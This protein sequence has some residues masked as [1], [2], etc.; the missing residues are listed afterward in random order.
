VQPRGTSVAAERNGQS[1]TKLLDRQNRRDPLSVSIR[2]RQHQ[3]VADPAIVPH[4]YMR[5]RGDARLSSVVRWYL[6]LR[7]LRRARSIMQAD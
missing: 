7:S 6:R 1:S 5:R 4:E 3:P 2:M